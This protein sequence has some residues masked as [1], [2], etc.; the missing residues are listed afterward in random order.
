MRT[1]IANMYYI[2]NISSNNALLLFCIIINFSNSTV[3]E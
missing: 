2:A 1:I 3:I